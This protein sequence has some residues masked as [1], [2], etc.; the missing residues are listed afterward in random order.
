MPIA[1]IPNCCTSRATSQPI[2]PMP[3]TPTVRPSRSSTSR[4]AHSWR[5]CARRNAGMFAA[6]LE[7]EHDD[8]VRDRH[9]GRTGRGRQ[10]DAAVEEAAEHRVVHAGAERVQPL[11][12]RRAR[13]LRRGTPRP[14]RA[15]D[16]ST[17]RRSCASA[18]SRGVDRLAR[19]VQQRSLLTGQLDD[20]GAAVVPQRGGDE[21]VERSCTGHGRIVLTGPLARSAQAG[22]RAVPALVAQRTV[23]SP[24]ADRG[25]AIDAVLA[26]TERPALLVVPRA[27]GVPSG[28]RRRRRRRDPAARRACTRARTS[29]GRTRGT[30]GRPGGD[31]PG[32]AGA[33]PGTTRP[34]GAGRRRADG[35]DR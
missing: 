22:A 11:E 10:A 31:D 16:R 24:L 27:V 33:R 14:S 20:L 8:V 21:Q 32:C 5:A 7:Q 6:R 25:R 13:R 28:H 34:T 29:P 26:A 12:V 18:S 9:R 15:T 2:G 30:S 3:M 1:R 17:G 35:R 4:G 23:G 19:D